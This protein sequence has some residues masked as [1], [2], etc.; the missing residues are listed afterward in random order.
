[1]NTNDHNSRKFIGRNINRMAAVIWLMLGI[2]VFRYAWIQLVEG[3][4]LAEWVRI[5]TGDNQVMQSPRG[6]IVDR[7]GRELA[8]SIMTQSLYI[9]P[10]SVK[11]ANDVA[12]KLAPVIGI[13]EKE[14][15]ADIAQG[16][17]FVWVKHYLSMDEVTQVKKL[18]EDEEYNCLNFI[19]EAKR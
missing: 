15:L 17:G 12:A 13:S 11:N 18:I 9:D 4:R 16:G 2:I 14:I 8:V 6:M 3:K 1:M 19:D 10:N 5:Q 7:N